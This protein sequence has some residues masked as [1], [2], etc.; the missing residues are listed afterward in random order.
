MRRRTQLF[1]EFA[2]FERG[3]GG[4]GKAGNICQMLLQ[5][6]APLN[7]FAHKASFI[8]HKQSH[9]QCWY[10]CVCVCVSLCVWTGHK[11]FMSTLGCPLPT[12]HTVLCCSE[13]R[14]PSAHHQHHSHLR[15]RSPKSLESL[16][17]AV[18]VDCCFHNAPKTHPSFQPPSRQPMACQ[19]A[20]RFGPGPNHAASF[21]GWL[22]LLYY[23]Q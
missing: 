14:S 3:Q 19:F 21:F 15:C 17:V 16:R 18:G 2:Q 10:V 4:G 1:R 13:L 12:V 8:K 20:C 11:M 9:C 23:C 7:K 22:A 5:F 6:F